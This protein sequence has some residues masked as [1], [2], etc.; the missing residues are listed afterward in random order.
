MTDTTTDDAVLR[1]P[2][3]GARIAASL[4]G[5]LLRGA[6][7]ITVAV[8]V[9]RLLPSSGVLEDRLRALGSLLLLVTIVAALLLSRFGIGRPGESA[10]ISPPLRG[11]WRAL[12]SPASRLPSHGTHD[13]GQT[14][15][16]DLTADD[17]DSPGFGTARR[18]LPPE[19]FPAFGR[20]VLAGGPGEV[21]LVRD[22]MRDHRSRNSWLLLPLFFVESILRGAAGSRFVFGNLVVIRLDAGGY[23][24][25]AHLRR[26]SARVAVGDRVSSSTVVAEVG[27]SGNSTEPHLHLQV[28][29]RA[30]P[31]G[32]VG[33]P[34]AFIDGPVP[35]RDD[36]VDWADQG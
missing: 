32:A 12:S 20:P 1:P 29:D 6:I 34:L 11:R 24:A 33:L 10:P 35:A 5:P 7:L 19:D 2:G 21:V 14:W 9:W 16:I 36:I 22:G 17:P 26:G 18:S 27:N 31:R 25:L 30:D 3:A 23:Q 8:T 13:A 4:R 28:M 15:A